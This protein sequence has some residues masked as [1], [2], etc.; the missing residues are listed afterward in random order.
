MGLGRMAIE[1]KRIS[2]G[3]SQSFGGREEVLECFLAWRWQRTRSGSFWPRRG[4]DLNVKVCD[5]TKKGGGTW[6]GE[7]GKEGKNLQVTGVF[8]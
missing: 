3:Y 8:T 6:G 1:G 2:F 5:S 4:G 7:E